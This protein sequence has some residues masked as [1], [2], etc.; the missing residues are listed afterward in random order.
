T[1]PPVGPSSISRLISSPGAGIAAVLHASRGG[2]QES[3][4]LILANA[5]LTHANR[6]EA[7][8]VMARAAC[9]GVNYRCLAPRDGGLVSPDT[10]INLEPGEVRILAAD[11]RPP[12]AQKRRINRAAGDKAVAA[13]RIGIERISPAVDDGRYPV[14]RLVGDVVVAEADVI[15][16]G[17]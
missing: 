9:D 4:R 16:D 11:A 10:V 15:C 6:M 1:A 2:N 14:K 13:H 12:A 7:S 17:H 3:A 5:D 8:A